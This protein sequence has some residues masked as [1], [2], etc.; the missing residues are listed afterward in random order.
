MASLF[1]STY[2]KDNNCVN[3]VQLYLGLFASG[4][5]SDFNAALYDEN[6]SKVGGTLGLVGLAKLLG[7]EQFAMLWAAMFIKKRIIVVSEHVDDLLQIT[8]TLPCLVW[9]RQQTWDIVK[10]IVNFAQ[11]LELNDIK[12]NSAIYVAGTLDNSVKSDSKLY[13]VLVDVSSQRVHVAEH[14]KGMCTTT[15]HV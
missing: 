1:V 2:E 9:H 10:P 11:E 15:I 3:L 13:D 6:K 8:R 14:V 7:V 5:S 12:T 4:K